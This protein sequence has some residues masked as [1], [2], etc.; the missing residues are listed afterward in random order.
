MN[1]LEHGRPMM[2]GHFRRRGVVRMGCSSAVP[3][4][5]VLAMAGCADRSGN[6]P[7]AMEPTR[8]DSRKVQ[9]PHTSASPEVS[10]AYL[11]GPWCYL[12]YQAGSKRSD[13]HIDYVFNEDGTL[14]YQN[15]PETPVDREGVWKLEDGQLSI[16]PSLWVV[17]TQ[18]HSVEDGRLVL[19]NDSSQLVLERGACE[20]EEQP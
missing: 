8:S 2:E 13:E 15:N 5:L 16:G 1:F 14:L 17:T 18:I 19:G 9:P 11:A 3:L 6:D 20:R 10:A 4:A 12:H 7:V